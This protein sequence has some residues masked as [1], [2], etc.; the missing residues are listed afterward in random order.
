MMST[1]WIPAIDAI[2]ICR[3]ES[4][5]TLVPPRSTR[6]TRAPA[7]SGVQ[8]TRRD[9]A[10]VD[11]TQRHTRTCGEA[12]SILHLG[13]QAQFGAEALRSGDVIDPHRDDDGRHHQEDK[14]LQHARRKAVGQLHRGPLLGPSGRA[15]GCD[16]ATARPEDVADLTRRRQ[17][18]TGAQQSAGDD[19][20]DTARDVQRTV[21]DQVVAA[22]GTREIRHERVHVRQR[23][24]DAG[25]ER[26]QRVDELGRV[27]HQRVEP[28]L[29]TTGDG[30]EVGGEIRRLRHQ[31][32]DPVALSSQDR[33]RTRCLAEERL[34]LLLAR[35][36]QR[37]RVGSRA[38]RPVEV[39]V[40]VRRA[41]Q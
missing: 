33:Y 2:V 7:P 11:A 6:S 9:R 31:C 5:G 12:E 25:V 37:R 34:D 27:G 22:D 32:G 41:G 21:E 39:G 38:H 15:G 1:L 35:G 36:H 3:N 18:L 40:V 10:H 16:R 13:M 14:E 4:A 26:G 23:G 29:T 17:R 24:A 28:V 30:V 20:V 8:R 19:L